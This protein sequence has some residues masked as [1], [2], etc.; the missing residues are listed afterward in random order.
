MHYL[1]NLFDKVLYIFRRGPLSI[2]RSISTL[3]TCNRYVS[4]W[5]CWRLLVDA[6]K[7]SMT[8]TYCMYTVLRYFWWWTVDL[9]ETCR[10]LYQI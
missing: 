8:N 2:I 5:F 4:C 7:T 10:G 9:S 1:S 6:N 3:Y